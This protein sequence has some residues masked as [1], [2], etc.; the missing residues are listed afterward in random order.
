MGF[1]AVSAIHDDLP[2]ISP[3]A[4]AF[5]ERYVV[6][7]RA[8]GTTYLISRKLEFHQRLSIDDLKKKANGAPHGSK[9]AFQN[10]ALCI[11]NSPGPRYLTH[12]RDGKCDAITYTRQLS[13]NQVMWVRMKHPFEDPFVEM[14][15]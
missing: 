5:S 13:W 11:M 2:R 9:I 10:A 4:R 7:H 14:W 12:P 1:A 15:L 3:Y 6:E 8:T